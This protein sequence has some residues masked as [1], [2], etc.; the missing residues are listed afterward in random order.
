MTQFSHSP[1]RLHPTEDLFDPLT[2]LLTD[3]VSRMS[4][5]PAINRTL[6]VLVVLRHM[7]SRVHMSRFR[8]EVL[9]VVILVRAHCN[10]LISRDSFDHHQCRVP[11][12]CTGG[13]QDSHIRHQPIAVLHKHMPAI[14]QLG[15]FPRSLPRQQCIR[16]RRRG[17]RLIAAPLAVKVYGRIARIVWRWLRSPVHFLKLFK[18]AHAS[19]NVPS[20]VKCSSDMR[21]KALACSTTKPKNCLATSAFSSRSRFFVNTVTSH[22]GSSIFSPTNQRNSRLY[23]NCSINR[24]SLRTVYSTCKMSARRSFSGGIDGRPILEY[25]CENARDNCFNTMS[26]ISRMARSG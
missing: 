9:G 5:G 14:T 6:A 21:L 8:H 15:F 16:I 17:M 4:R 25:I 24:R 3:R 19:S 10:R 13:L 23:S 26:V 7:R 12:R 1:N 2:L 20:T 11:L 22:T 18:P